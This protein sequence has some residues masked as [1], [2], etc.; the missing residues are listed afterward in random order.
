MRVNTYDIDGCVYINDEIGG[1]YPGPY[2]FLITGRSFE[3]YDETIAMLS[4]RQITNRVFFNPAKFADKTRQ[5][6]GRHKALIIKMLQQEG[7]QVMGHFDDD[8]IQAEI[9]RELCPEI[10]VIMIVH[11]LTEKENVRHLRGT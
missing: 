8:E 3:E 6:S 9:I 10:K 11:D 5:G 2:D 4:D 7:Y 1:I